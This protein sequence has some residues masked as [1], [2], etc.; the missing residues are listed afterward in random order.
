MDEIG[1]LL[2]V[3]GENWKLP[4]AVVCWSDCT[5]GVSLFGF[6]KIPTGEVAFNEP[7]FWQGLKTK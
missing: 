3:S 1:P 4:E 2:V 7:F 6:F 5:C